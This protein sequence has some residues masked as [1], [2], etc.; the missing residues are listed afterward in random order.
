MKD[1]YYIDGKFVDDDQCLISARDLIVLRGYGIFDF[2]VTYNRRPFHL[3][4]HVERFENSARYIRLKLNHTQKEI[5]AAVEETVARNTHHKE[6][7]IRM[8]YTGGG[9][10]DGTTPR[11]NGSLLVMVT[12]KITL[13]AQC[14]TKGVKVITNRIER[15]LP[16]AKSTNYLSAVYAMEQ[17]RKQQSVE[18]IYVDP[19]DRMLEGTTSN[20]FFF[21]DGK[22]ITVERGILPGVTRG[23]LLDLLRHR[24]EV[25]MRDVKMDELTSMDEIFITSSTKEVV[26]VVQVDEISIGDGR[27][28][29]Q[30]RQVME[31]FSEYTD[32]YGRGAE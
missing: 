5:I 9:S 4:E 30:T 25:Q 3:K 32:K 8:I 7:G 29:P 6:S 21:K 28:G 26:P 18:S 10:L 14:Y 12:P 22:L 27:P 1:I 2:L 16:D 19:N 23:V 13:P 17:A 11:D 31:I 24:F 15:I 20:I